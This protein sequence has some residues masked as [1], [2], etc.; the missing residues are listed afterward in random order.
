MP[1]SGR[2]C[3]VSPRRLHEDLACLVRQGFS[4]HSSE[5]ARLKCRAGAEWHYS[6]PDDHLQACSKG[7]EGRMMGQRA[8]MRFFYCSVNLGFVKKPVQ[9]KS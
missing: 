3:W 5:E 4:C 1:W 9:L 2:T 6:T 8:G 7:E